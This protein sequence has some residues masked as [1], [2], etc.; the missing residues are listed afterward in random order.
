M[1][2]QNHLISRL[3]AAS[4]GQET[5]NFARIPKRASVT[6]GELFAAAQ[7]HVERDSDNAEA[8]AAN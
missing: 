4:I 8:F 2:D 5:R 6:F 3:H 7:S 1:Y